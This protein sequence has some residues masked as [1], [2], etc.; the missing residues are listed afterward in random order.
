[1]CTAHL[2]S[3][4]PS[5]SSSSSLSLKV[6]CGELEACT[7]GASVTV[8]KGK[9]WHIHPCLPHP[10]SWFTCFLRILCFLKLRKLPTRIHNVCHRAAT[11][12]PSE[13]RF[14]SEAG[15]DEIFSAEK[16]SVSLRTTDP[17]RFTASL[18]ALGHLVPRSSFLDFELG[19]RFVRVL[20]V[21]GEKSS[22]GG[23]RGGGRANSWSL[24]PFE[25]ASCSSQTGT[26]LTHLYFCRKSDLY[27][28]QVGTI[29]IPVTRPM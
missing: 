25:Q 8:M 22:G 10:R 15:A 5:G 13:E 6:W 21:Q 2:V 4:P 12:K 16:Q 27:A 7:F 11:T 9:M 14:A 28:V 23:V 3:P 1:M 19:Q 24:L 26:M 29:P 20:L 18:G 17:H